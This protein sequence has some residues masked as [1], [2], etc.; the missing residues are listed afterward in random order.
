MRP[1]PPQMTASLTGARRLAIAVQSPK[2]RVVQEI[3]AFVE[4]LNTAGIHFT[5]FSKQTERETKGG[6]G[7]VPS[8]MR[9]RPPAGSKP[10]HRGQRPHAGRATE[11]ASRIGLETDWNCCISMTADGV[12]PNDKQDKAQMPRGIDKV[13]RQGAGRRPNTPSLAYRRRLGGSWR[14]ASL[15]N[16]AAPLTIPP[17]RRF[18]RTSKMWTTFRSGCRPSPTA[19]RTPCRK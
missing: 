4:L 6:G 13:G 1:L 7:V 15:Q 2:R 5:Y 11:Y 3:P 8:W 14:R 10:H 12:D 18:G 19:R 17:G 16:G 9:C